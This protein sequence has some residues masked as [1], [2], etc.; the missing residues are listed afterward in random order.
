MLGLFGSIQNVAIPTQSGYPL[1]PA[2]GH[3]TTIHTCPTKG[4]QHHYPPKFRGLVTPPHAHPNRDLVHFFLQGITGGFCI[5]YSHL[6]SKL[7]SSKRNMNSARTHATIVDDY[8]AEEVQAGC[9][10]GPFPSNAIPN[11]QV[12][13]F[14]VIPK[15]HQPNKWRLIVDLSHPKGKSVNDGIPK[16]LCS[17]S[18]ISVDDAIQKIISL[19]RGTLLAKIDIKSAFR[20]I[21][22]HPADHHLL[23]M[24]W[25][26]A[27]Y[28]DTCL[29]FGL[30]SAPKLFNV[31]A[32]LLE[33]ILLHLGVSVLPHYLND[34]LTMGPP[35]TQICHQNLRLLIEVCTML[36]IPLALE[37]VE[38]PSTI[39]EFLGILLDTTCMEARLPAKKLARIQATIQEWLQKKS[40][41]KRDILSLVGLLQHAAKVVH[42]GCTFVSRMYSVAASVQELDYFT[43]L[44]R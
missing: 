27:T 28:I 12:S 10:T 43:R 1:V 41:K 40:A 23:A 17:M 31:L 3:G 20:L 14:G 36:G 6:L 8:L 29:P 42:L 11:A 22:V 33:W 13:C 25:R 37:K 4:M 16:H 32:D 19:G 34:Y 21:P 5:G 30:R 15:A 9:M 7:K 18:Y 24:E 38:G 35:N 2:G 44:N 39:L 26:G